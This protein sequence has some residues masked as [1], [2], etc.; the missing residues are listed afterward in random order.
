[1]TSSEA[2]TT[3]SLV[4][5]PAVIT[6]AVTLLRLVG[7]RQGWAPLFFSRAPGGAGAI[8]G[9]VW[10]VP[11][12][13]VYFAR[14]LAAGEGAPSA[15]RVIGHALLA[16]AFLAVCGFIAAGV[17][18][19]PPNALFGVLLFAAV[20]A[21]VITY[22]AWPVLGRKLLA[23]GLAARLPVVIVMLVAILGDWGTHYDLP[24][25]GFPVMAPIAKWFLIGLLPQMLLWVPF[26]IFV[27]ALF[28][29]FALI[30]RRRS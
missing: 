26:T 21:A 17:L 2:Q 19:L 5:V 27:G 24:P 1:M 10:L 8:V 30:G 7:E 6:L 29:G 14:K 4:L 9:I 16:I 20:I 22:R 18:K 11:V 25:P 3:K 28:G 15:G 12:F 13:G 23:Y